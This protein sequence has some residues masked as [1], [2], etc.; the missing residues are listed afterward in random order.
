MKP[1]G[2]R[3]ITYGMCSEMIYRPLSSAGG[4]IEMDDNRVT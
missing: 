2:R 3:T 1:V 4:P